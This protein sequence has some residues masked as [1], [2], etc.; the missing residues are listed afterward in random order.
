[1]AQLEKTV[2]IVTNPRQAK[3]KVASSDPTAEVNP[4]APVVCESVLGH[5]SSNSDFLHRLSETE[6]EVE[7][8][9]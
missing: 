4:M 9:D 6:R 5:G 8:D 3:A 2:A 1:M 7:G